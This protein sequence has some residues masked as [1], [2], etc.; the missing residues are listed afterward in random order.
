MCKFSLQ[1]SL[2]YLRNNVLVEEDWVT[3][4]HLELGKHPESL[5]KGRF[6]IS[7]EDGWV[8]LPELTEK[9]DLKILSEEGMRHELLQRDNGHTT[10]SS[11]DCGDILSIV[12]RVL[13]VPVVVVHH[14]SSQFLL[15]QKVINGRQASVGWSQVLLVNQVHQVHALGGHGGYQKSCYDL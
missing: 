2:T 5:E 1:I 4:V 12:K 7:S 8:L 13:G 10:V 14:M 9:W 11:E 3:E 6:H 15:E